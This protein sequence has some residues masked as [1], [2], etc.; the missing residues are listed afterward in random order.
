[1]AVREIIYSREFQV[2]E[3]G[4]LDVNDFAVRG[5]LR[6]QF[7]FKE[8]RVDGCEEWEGW[9]GMQRYS[10]RITS[11]K[12]P[13]RELKTAAGKPYIV[14]VEIKK[15]GDVDVIRGKSD[16]EEFLM[17]AGFLPRTS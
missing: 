17:D 12:E 3:A 15:C 6:K 8:N 5:E 10:Y 16:L 14:S 11:S 2:P 13:F 7:A 4:N 1:M 9:D